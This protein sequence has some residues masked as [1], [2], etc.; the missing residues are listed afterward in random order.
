MGCRYIIMEENM[1]EVYVE[2]T[3]PDGEVEYW[4]D[5]KNVIPEL[6]RLQKIHNGKIEVKKVVKT[7]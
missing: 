6:E 5:D 3:Y 1:K 4:M 7:S 2:V